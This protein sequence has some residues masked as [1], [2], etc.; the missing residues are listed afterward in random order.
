MHI[1]SKQWIEFKRL[2]FIACVKSC[3]YVHSIK[4]LSC[5]TGS[6]AHPGHATH[7]H[8]HESCLC[9]YTSLSI[10]APQFSS[11]AY[12]KLFTSILQAR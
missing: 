1:L 11:V 10:Y 2:V 5:V 6:V 3:F 7:Y 4:V 8:D 12:V 9:M